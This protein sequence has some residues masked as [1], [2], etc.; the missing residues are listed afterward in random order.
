MQYQ[1]YEIHPVSLAYV[2]L[3]FWYVVMGIMSTNKLD[4]QNYCNLLKL[5][6]PKWPNFKN[7][8]KYTNFGHSSK[9]E[10]FIIAFRLKRDDV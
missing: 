5:K 10:L 3:H 8:M 7:N 1:N 6:P 9:T 2:L 4:K